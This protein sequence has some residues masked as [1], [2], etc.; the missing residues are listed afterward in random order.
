VRFIGRGFAGQRADVVVGLTPITIFCCNS[1]VPLF[2]ACAISSIR[3]HKENGTSAS[4]VRSSYCQEQALLPKLN[5][6][7]IWKFDNKETSE[8]HYSSTALPFS[9]RSAPAHPF[10]T[11][12]LEELNFLRLTK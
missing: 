6:E 4:R 8:Y 12:D 5:G 3:S 11:V 2:V 9:R 7:G 10:P 1:H